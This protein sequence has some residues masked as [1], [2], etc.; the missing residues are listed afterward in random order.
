MKIIKKQL[1]LEYKFGDY[2]LDLLKKRTIKKPSFGIMWFSW[3]GAVE[4]GKAGVIASINSQL[5][6]LS[7]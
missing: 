1:F 2:D 5:S 6:K 4:K 7:K 3:D